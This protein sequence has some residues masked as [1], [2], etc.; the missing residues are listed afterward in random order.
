[1][2]TDMIELSL[3]NF[4]VNQC[5]QWFN[6]ILAVISIKSLITSMSINVIPQT[7]HLPA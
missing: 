3:V 4:S 6:K 5:P 2:N 1:M 7:M